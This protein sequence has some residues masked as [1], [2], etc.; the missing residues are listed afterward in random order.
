MFPFVTYKVT[1]A[2]ERF[3]ARGTCKP[4]CS[5]N[6]GPDVVWRN[7]REVETSMK[8]MVIKS[9]NS[10]DCVQIIDVAIWENI[11]RPIVWIQGYHGAGV[12]WSGWSK[13]STEAYSH[14]YKKKTYANWSVAP[15]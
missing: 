11:V 2:I 15:E 5:R 7:F 9:R 14:Y 8:D 13:D 10:R 6:N 1:F 12:R 3:V 4:I